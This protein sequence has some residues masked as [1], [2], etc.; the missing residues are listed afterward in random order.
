MMKGKIH[1]SV[2]VGLSVIS[3]KKSS[4]RIDI[5]A[6]EFIYHL[7]VKNRLMFSKWVSMLKHHR[8]FRQHEIAFGNRINAVSTPVR[9]P[10]VGSAQTSP[11]RDMNSKVVA[12]ILDST[13]EPLDTSKDMN[14]LQLK[15]VK[16]SS[17]LKVIEMQAESNSKAMAE[18]TVSLKKRR[19]FLR[20]RR[21][22][23]NT[24]NVPNDKINKKTNDKSDNTIATNDTLIDKNRTNLKPLSI[25]HHLSSS[26]PSL[27]ECDGKPNLETNTATNWMPQSCN[28]AEME[29]N[30]N[31]IGSNGIKETKAVV[32]FVHLANDG[33]SICANIRLV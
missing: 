26:H 24:A 17:L 21:K 30:P 12:W 23:N 18:E 11:H 15:L 7:K 19:R 6:E 22:A 3:T 4:K 2:D 25:G 10:V 20:L 16:L 29:F 32:D 8:L 5:D 33:L 31:T 14:E 27:N 1:G 28:E 13:I 9:S